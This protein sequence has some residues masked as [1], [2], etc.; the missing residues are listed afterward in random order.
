MYF[1]NKDEQL[2]TI[3]IGEIINAFRVNEVPK[4][5]RYY[6]YY[7]GKQDILRKVVNDDTKPNNKIVTNYCNSIVATY[8]GYLTGKDITYTSDNDISDIQE[9][10]NYN[11]VSF[12]DNT[13][14]KNSLIFGVSYEVL[15]VDADGKQRFK[16]L[17]P[18]EVIPV[19]YNTLEQELAYVIRFYSVNNTD[20]INSEFYI[21]IYSAKEVQNYKSDSSFTSFQLLDMIPNYYQ[22]VP[23]IVFPLNEEW[24]SIFDKIM[25]LQDAYNTL[26]S[27]EVDDFQAFV[28]AYLVLQG[29]DDVDPEALHL[30]R[31]NRVLQLPQGGSAEFLTK[32]ISDT[33]ISNM[34][35]SIRD[36]I[37]EISACPDFNDN[38]FGTSSG[39]A[40]KYKLLNFE[41]RAGSIEKQMT[42]ALQRRIE[43]I[44]AITSLI[45]GEDVWRDIQ[46]IFT[47]NLPIDYADITSMIN[48]L[49]G[50]VSN[51][52]LIAQLPFVTD[53]DAELEAVEEQNAANASLYNF[54]SSGNEVED[55]EL[56]EG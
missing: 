37:R 25:S 41:N 48:N 21:D 29:I 33:Q 28:M 47:R 27:S 45:K 13:L 16:Y 24:E 39:V 53:V 32:N 42:M 34:L 11:D 54:S 5:N 2:S 12:E 14:L 3:K 1:I 19:Y 17:D 31:T 30:M 10:L 20:L 51:K 26:L 7:L 9:I 36:S 4:M 49:R 8:N 46:I 38:A 52:T 56:L 43:L 44:C 23:V 55:D 40:I 15:W 22:Q 50:L 35:D 18:R 6:N